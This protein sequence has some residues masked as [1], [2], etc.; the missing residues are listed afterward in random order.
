M[1][2]ILIIDDLLTPQEF[3]LLKFRGKN[4]YA[5]C[6]MIPNLLRDVL[7]VTGQDVFEVDMRWDIMDDDRDFYGIWWGKRREDKWT[8]T[9]VKITAQGEQNVKDKTGDITIMI[10][11]YLETRYEYS[12]FIQK[13]F[14][15]FFNYMF[16][17]KQRRRYLDF[18][19]DNIYTLRE[20]IL[21]MLGI[22]REEK[23]L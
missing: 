12:N 2:K 19:K 14:W 1:P 11:G 8:T 22:S 20:K 17:Y 16:Y 15:W 3:I 4:P 7:K 21:S 10:K 13:S 9:R 23:L 18:S 6:T 5:P